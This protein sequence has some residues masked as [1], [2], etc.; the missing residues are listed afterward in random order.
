[1]RA[2]SLLPGFASVFMSLNDLL[3]YMYTHKCLH[4]SLLHTER[5]GRLRHSVDTCALP[6]FGC[7]TY[8]MM[9]CGPCDT[10]LRVHASC[11]DPPILIR[12]CLHTQGNGPCRRCHVQANCICICVC[13]YTYIH[14]YTYTYTYIH[15][16]IHT[17]THT[18][19]YHMPMQDHFHAHVATMVVLA[20]ASSRVT[21]TFMHA[22][23]APGQYIRN[24]YIHTYI[25]TY[26][27][28]DRQTDKSVMVIYFYG[29]ALLCGCI[30]SRVRII[31]AKSAA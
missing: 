29:H 4:E 15:T 28:T 23:A 8:E 26:I 13:I 1:M 10:F 7:T 12:L 11:S 22:L 25:H 21:D 14:I 9:G 20:C 24:T 19:I 6:C 30:L 5:V 3:S 16:Y 31:G 27:Q 17:Y 18:H 2:T